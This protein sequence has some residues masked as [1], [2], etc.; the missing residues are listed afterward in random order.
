M[1]DLFF[2]FLVKKQRLFT[3]RTCSYDSEDHAFV[4]DGSGYLFTLIW[5][6]L[7]Q[8]TFRSI[9][10]EADETTF[11]KWVSLQFEFISTTNPK[12]HN[13]SSLSLKYFDLIPLNVKNTTII[14]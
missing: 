5:I 1:D 6:F 9:L 8:I 14:D 2:E 7:F 13:F 12:Y 10:E 11:L 4:N 3:S